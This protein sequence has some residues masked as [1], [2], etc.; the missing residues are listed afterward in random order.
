MT[1][2]IWKNLFLQR[3][4]CK[5]CFLNDWLICM[6]LIQFICVIYSCS[7]CSIFFIFSFCH[8]LC[9]SLCFC[10]CSVLIFVSI[11]VAILFL[12]ECQISSLN[13]LF[14]D[15]IYFFIF[16]HF[17]FLEKRRFFVCK[18]LKFRLFSVFCIGG[19]IFH[20]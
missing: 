6:I 20:M 17:H 10:P 19:S 3:F 15:R 2:Y 16:F 8:C 18:C 7:G 5:I 4:L 1:S 13:N 11:S 12:I 14:Y 9:N